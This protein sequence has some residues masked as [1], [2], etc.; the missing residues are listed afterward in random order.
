MSDDSY[1]EYSRENGPISF[2]GPDATRLF[3]CQVLQSAIRLLKSNITPTRGLTMKK[4]LNLATHFTKKEYKRG[5]ADKAIVDLDKWIVAMRA[6]L[7]IEAR[8]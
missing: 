4:A 1:I 6:A 5:E 2:V 7:P 3:Q 8:P